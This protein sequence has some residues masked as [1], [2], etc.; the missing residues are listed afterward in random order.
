MAKLT[1]T[2][3]DLYYLGEVEVPPHATVEVADDVLTRSYRSKALAALFATG[4]LVTGELAARREEANKEHP[5][6]KGPA[7]L[8]HPKQEK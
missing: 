5:R 6:L 2:T 8:V 1:N 4:R 7:A 3:D